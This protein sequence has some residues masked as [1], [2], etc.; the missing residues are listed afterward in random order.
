MCMLGGLTYIVLNGQILKIIEPSGHSVGRLHFSIW[1]PFS[2][3][4]HILFCFIYP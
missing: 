1:L 4:L 3:D 2:F